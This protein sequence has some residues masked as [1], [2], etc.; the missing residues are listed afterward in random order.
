MRAL[1]WYAVLACIGLSVG[2][3]TAQIPVPAFQQS[4]LTNADLVQ[5]GESIVRNAA[6]C[7]HCH[8][9]DPKRDPDGPLSGGMEFSDWRI[10]TARASNL[11]PDPETGLGKW[12]EGEIVRAL[13]NGQS[14]DGRLLAPVM[15]YEWFHEMADSDALAV[16]RYLMSQSPVKNDV[17]QSPNFWFKLGKVFL[18]RP[19]P[20]ISV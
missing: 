16:A 6:V 11:T 18:L 3:R 15:P 20:A 8:A 17:K 19:K 7:G 14:R 10:G 5:R 4:E 9:A 13:R 2:C 12:S 1:R